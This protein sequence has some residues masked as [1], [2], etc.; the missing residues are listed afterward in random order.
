MRFWKLWDK[1]GIFILLLITLAIFAILTPNIL[2]KDNLVNILVQTSMV[3]IAAAGMT[4][5]ITG[6]GFDLSIGATLTIATCILG[7]NIPIMGLWPAFALTIAVGA[8]LGA[9]NGFII[10]KFKV[11]TFVATLATMVLYRGVALIYTQGRDA[12]LMNNREIKI[13]SGGDIF[14]IPVPIFLTVLIFVLAYI[15]YKYTPF[16]LYV[17]SIGSNQTASR[18]SGLQVDRVIIWIF[19]ITAVTAAIAGTIQTSQLLT[20]NATFGK[21]FE[22][23][24]ITATILGGTSLAGGRGNVWGT[25]SAAIM[26]GI[27]KNGLNLLSVTDNYQ[28]LVTGLILILALSMSGIREIVKKGAMA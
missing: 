14:S 2:T 4:F 12:T 27:I 24:V 8:V 1:T 15:V 11:Q 17:R 28:R 25:L 10:T 13:F 18:I 3:A 5:A 20:G 9:I 7:K 23:E 19:V 22:L 16:G 26:L 21:G 6:G